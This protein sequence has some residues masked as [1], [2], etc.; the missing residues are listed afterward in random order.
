M[1]EA[2]LN[3]Y[4]HNF[5]LK[6]IYALL[7]DK[8]FLQN[9]ADLLSSEY[10]ES[11]AHKWVIDFIL[12][13]YGKYNT[14]PTPEV[15][16]VELKKEKNDVL[17]VAIKETLKDTYSS[18]ETD[19][20]YVKEEFFNFCKNQKLKQALLSSVDLL[21]E[22]NFDGIRTVI[23]HALKDGIEK[24]QIHEY[25]KD[26]ESR[27]RDDARSP[28]PFP[29]PSLN[30]RTQGGIGGG[31]LM[32]IVSNPKGGKSWGS[33]AVAGNAALLG[34]NVLYYTLELSEDYVGKRFDAYFTGIEVDQL[35]EYR[36]L[37]T[38]TVDKVQ[39]TIR[40]KAYPPGRATITTLEQYTRRL[41]NKDGF[42]PHL[43]VIDYLD[44]L[45]NN[46]N[47]KDSIEDGNDVY[48]DAKGMAMELNIPI[49]SPSQ[50]NRT[51]SN[52]D[53][54]KGE[55]LAG[56]YEKLMIG[57]LILSV[58]KKSNIWYIMGNR[59]GD[60]D[61]AFKSSFNRKNG[62]IVIDMEEY[63]EEGEDPTNTENGGNGYL[64]GDEL[65]KLRSKL[66]KINKE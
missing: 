22:G 49:I 17:R 35:T 54:I 15:L 1:S 20:E 61:K 24:E 3:N 51:A 5:Q 19:A 46:K 52:I 37:V 9:I 30:K 32:I 2:S 4:G 21:K 43:I 25:E 58:S 59:Y 12:K 14:Y 28:I 48:T 57:D 60:D 8:H 53:I 7:I 55:H 65:G 33:I 18:D 26:I 45:R 13:Y 47:R 56:T 38:E 6:V 10:F 16:K 50:A 27:Y 23:D 62:H 40:I 11:P 39:G 31:D 66:V 36:D 41:K 42:V 63:D 34:Y 44:K 29:W 64:G